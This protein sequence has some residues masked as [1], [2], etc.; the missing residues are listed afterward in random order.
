ME[1][2]LSYY[3]NWIEDLILRSFLICMSATRVGA[4]GC[5]IVYAVLL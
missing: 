3:K 1:N 5:C 2:E 4:C